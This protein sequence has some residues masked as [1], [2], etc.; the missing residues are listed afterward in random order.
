MSVVDKPFVRPHK[1]PAPIIAMNN[2]LRSY[3]APYYRLQS[4]FGAIENDLGIDLPIPL[5]QAKYRCFARG[6]T[7][8]L[9]ANATST[10]IAFVHFDLTV[11]KRRFPFTCFCN[12]LPD[13]EIDNIHYFCGQTGQTSG[14]TGT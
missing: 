6:A 12:T 3:T 5:K 11:G 2:G 13:F 10:K 9:A 7:S 14:I 1:N 8:S 4:G